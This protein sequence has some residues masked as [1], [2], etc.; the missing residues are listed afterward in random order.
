MTDAEVR[1]VDD[2]SITAVTVHRSGSTVERRVA[3][4][5]G[6]GWPAE[7]AIVGLPLALS[8]ATARVRVARV[9]GAGAAFAGDPH[10]GLHARPAAGTVEAPAEAAL[11]EA[12]RAVLR[13]ERA[14]A[15]R[16]A[17][18]AMLAS[19]GIEPRPEPAEGRAPPASPMEA[20]LALVEF[21]DGVG[22]AR[23][24]EIEAL[25]AT[26]GEQR[27]ALA[28]LED[29]AR[30]ASA[31]QTVD[32][33]AVTKALRV[34]LSIEGEVDAVELA[35]SYAVPG[36]R[37]VPA[38]QVRLDRAGRAASIEMRAHV[39]QRTGEDWTGVRLTVSTADPVRF[40]A[41]PTLR[42]IRIGKA[43]APS[44]PTP[45]FRPPPRGAE[46]LFADFDRDRKALRAAAPG[47]SS[48]PS[49]AVAAVPETPVWA[50]PSTK[51]GY[52][53]VGS[54]DAFADELVAD[55][56]EEGGFDGMVMASAGA[57]PPPMAR[58]APAPAAPRGRAMRKRSAS[59]AEV[60][61]EEA[62]SGF[63]GALGG[64]G[65]APRPSALDFAALR[66]PAADGSERGKLVAVEPGTRYREGLD[67][68][69]RRLSFDPVAA[70]QAAELHAAAV[71]RL[72]LPG[73]TRAV[74]DTSGL[75]DHAWTATA[76][77]DVPADGGW[78]ALPLSVEAL[79]CALRYVVVPRESTH[80]FRLAALQ[81]PGNAP[82][83]GGPV[84]VYVDDTYVLSTRLPT[85]PAR[86]RF[87]LGLGV[88]QGLRCARN[89][90]FEELRSDARV[91]AMTELRHT[92]AVE[93]VN[94]LNLPADV[95]VRERIP[96]PA[97]GAEVVV[98]ELA[99]EPPWEAYTQLE[100][101]RPLVGGRRWRVEVAPGE[102]AALS[103]T[104]VVKIYA[105]NEL[106]GGNRREA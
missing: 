42:S 63:G 104:Y 35:V 22:E 58:A 100:R 51:G 84:E 47:R 81:N 12:R 8:D 86:G 17:E 56:D 49:P 71:A 34:A 57:P 19:A 65:G 43:Q 7:L 93:L 55:F 66:L 45:G 53:A 38:W 13:T 52:G 41:L 16:E 18:L 44:G 2:S 103:A 80:V 68:D 26:L 92:I 25:R 106:V 61:R 74:E 31:A 69:G 29:E 76:P 4:K 20:R 46:A 87:D 9:E 1:V 89:T 23:H 60:L 67:G 78:H 62:P 27:E 97:E 54:A 64:G 39:A 28:R 72:A 88:E 50:S 14:I 24:D 102:S 32:A 75:Y 95:E 37:W 91:V 6:D 83:L 70:V 5:R 85:V 11:R 3:V 40:T 77:V 96:Q 105:A 94:R 10:V 33:A 15:Q 30:R 90:R 48:P 101:S 21:T 82:L 98:E 79:P 59:K 73:D 36:A 99:V